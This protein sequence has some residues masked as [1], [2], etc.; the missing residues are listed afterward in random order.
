MIFSGI[1]IALN[2]FMKLYQKAICLL[3]LFSHYQTNAATH[4]SALL[5]NIPT[6]QAS[7]IPRINW[8]EIRNVETHYE[9]WSLLGEWLPGW[10]QHY[11]GPLQFGRGYY[12]EQKVFLK[13][14]DTNHV[15]EFSIL[16]RLN[17]KGLGPKLIAKFRK[18][19]GDWMVLELLR[20]D[21]FRL[22]YAKIDPNWMDYYPTQD[23]SGYK[24]HWANNILMGT[25]NINTISS[26]IHIFE[27]LDTLGIAA[28]D[29]QF[30][31]Q[32]DGFARLLDTGL[33]Q[34]S[35]AAQIIN[36]KIKK[37]VLNNLQMLI[38]GKEMPYPDHGDFDII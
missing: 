17:E 4:C 21:L 1:D 37:A 20:G 5:R 3:L 12:N 13:K 35:V 9:H 19:H 38:D 25:V 33:Y 11:D 18:F 31:V 30:M 24:P 32:K 15:N 26:V 8:K 7:N 29:F 28:H 23:G 6:S 14:I 16:K 2:C 36:N 34:S 10:V 22:D 27:Q